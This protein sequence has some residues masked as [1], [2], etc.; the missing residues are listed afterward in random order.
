MIAPDSSYECLDIDATA[1]GEG[2][3]RELLVRNALLK[4]SLRDPALVGLRRWRRKKVK[5]KS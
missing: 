3:A 5:V 4:P 2:A 1:G